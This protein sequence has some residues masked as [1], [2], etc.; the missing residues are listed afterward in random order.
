MFKLVRNRQTSHL[1]L[2]N[3]QE[4][5]KQSAQKHLHKQNLEYNIN[6]RTTKSA[7]LPYSDI[8]TI[9]REF[10]KSHSLTQ[11]YAPIF[12]VGLFHSLLKYSLNY[13]I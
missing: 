12:D 8:K 1:Y 5:W 2:F 10:I 13:H 4:T 3:A 7:R 11:N 6:I 9:Q